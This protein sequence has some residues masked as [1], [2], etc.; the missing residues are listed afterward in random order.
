MYKYIFNNTISGHRSR[1]NLLQATKQTGHRILTGL[2]IGITLII[3]WIF[4]TLYLII[5]N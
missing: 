4:I 2:K 1:H 3:F 5:N